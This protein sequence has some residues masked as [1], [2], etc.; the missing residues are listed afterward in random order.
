VMAAQMI[1]PA[2]S[3][4]SR[5]ESAKL[6]TSARLTLNSRQLPDQG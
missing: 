5:S 6:S 3:I 1:T 2:R 4:A